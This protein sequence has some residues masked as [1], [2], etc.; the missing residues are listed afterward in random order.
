MAGPTASRSSASAASTRSLYPANFVNVD[1]STEITTPCL[2][3][4]DRP[5]ATRQA[6]AAMAAAQSRALRVVI[7]MHTS[8][9]TDRSLYVVSRTPAAAS[10]TRAT[11]PR[12]SDVSL[13][14][15]D[16]TAPSNAPSRSPMPLKFC[17]VSESN[18]MRRT[19]RADTSP[20]YRPAT[21]FSNS[22]WPGLA[23]WRS[24]SPSSSM[25]KSPFGSAQ[26]PHSVL[27]IMRSPCFRYAAGSVSTFRTSS[28]RAQL[29]PVPRM[30]AA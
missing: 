8:R 4:P 18:A 14:T 1:P 6:T 2:S 25:A 30:T 13:Y 21:S 12:S 9:T 28:T 29:V 27:M 15:A 20:M 5:A 11:P 24:R 3:P 23:L 22:P 7:A 17:N 10:N 19:I 16:T 26:S